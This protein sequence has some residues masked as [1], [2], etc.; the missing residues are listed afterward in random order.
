MRD[1]GMAMGPF[2]VQDLTGLQIGWANRKR[3]AP[4]RDPKERYETISDTLCEMDRL[5]Q[6]SGKGWYRYEEGNRAPLRDAEV[7]DLIVR[8]SA[9]KGITRR[10]YSHAEIRDRMLSA[11]INEG[12]RIVEE[13]IAEDDAAVDMVKLHGYG[14]PRW[15]GG[16]MQYGKEIGWETVAMHMQQ[17]AAESPDSWIIA[18]RFK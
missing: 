14:F 11:L 10:D 16:P 8:Y 17:V 1:F 15:R 12:A 3:Q 7:E 13:G 5:G 4:T 6:R 18:E 2:E 9:D